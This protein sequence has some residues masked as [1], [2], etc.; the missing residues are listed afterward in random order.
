MIDNADGVAAGV[1]KEIDTVKRHNI[2]SLYYF[3]DETTKEKTA[4]EQSIIG[5]T[6]AKSK[7]VHQF[8]E[9][10]RDGAR[11]LINDIVTIYLNYCRG[12]LVSKPEDID[13]GFHAV[14][15]Q[16][17][18]SYHAPAMPKTIL[19]N[20][21]KCKE[22]ILKQ[23]LGF[24]SGNPF[25]KTVKTNEIDE[26]GVQFL[27]VL[28]EERSIKH[29]NTGMFL[30]TLKEQ[31][32]DE[33]FQIVCIRW[34][35]IQAHFL[36]DIAKCI[37]SLEAALKLSKETKQPAWVIQD[38]LIDLRNQ[39][40]ILNTA[41]N[42]YTES[43]AQKELRES[44][45]DVYYPV[46]DRIHS[47][48]HEKYIGGLYKKKTESPYSVTIGNDFSQYVALLASSFIVSI[49]STMAH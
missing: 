13:D 15:L 41:N 28:F 26:W 45:E 47:S 7:T 29:F 8:D 46:L 35:A 30:D 40:W 14:N 12:R 32:T 42:C 11:A 38:I 23:T 49:P 10:S 31:Q 2:K 3:C 37:E 1:Q 17:N 36:G 20:I 33:Y 6:F 48:L 44:K 43:H 27:P 18:A 39:H 24:S 22:Y 16:E 25:H 21:D 34:Q 4:L 5:A 19:N 9:L